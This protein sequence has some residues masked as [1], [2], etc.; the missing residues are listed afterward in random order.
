[1][2]KP[3]YLSKLSRIENSDR[4]GSKIDI[5]YDPLT[6]AIVNVLNTGYDVGDLV[7]TLNMTKKVRGG[8]Y[9]IERSLIDFNNAGLPSGVTSITK[10]IRKLERSDE[11]LPMYIIGWHRYLEILLSAVSTMAKVEAIRVE[12]YPDFVA[13]VNGS[14]NT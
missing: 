13:K 14:K 1:M 3:D 9:T 10:E 8:T 2:S 4:S 11:L 6:L 12:D 5:F 7:S